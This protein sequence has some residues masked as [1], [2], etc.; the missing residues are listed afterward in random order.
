MRYRILEN[1][2]IKSII[3]KVLLH[4]K[5]K[6]VVYRTYEWL[7]LWISVSAFN[8]FFTFLCTEVN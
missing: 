5:Y 7:N 1:K 3:L 6:T 8:Y 2:N 4:S